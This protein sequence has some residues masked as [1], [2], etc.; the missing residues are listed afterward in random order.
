MHKLHR[1]AAPVCLERHQRTFGNDW[2]KVSPEDKTKIWEALQV[3]QLDRC[4]YCESKITAPKQH[5]EHFRSRSRFPQETFDWLNIFGSCND[6]DHCGKHKDNKQHVQ[7]DLI[8][9]DAEDP[10]KLL[11]FVADGTV[12]IRR[13]L[14]QKTTI[15]QR[16]QLEY[17]ISMHL[18]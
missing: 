5:I 3:M 9:P 4:A 14:S 12:A 2:Q 11:I 16:R 7:S 8:K 17:L 13:N 15:G 10:E 6:Q 1:R 18:L